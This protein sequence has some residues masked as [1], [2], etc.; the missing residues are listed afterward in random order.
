[1]VVCWHGFGSDQ[2]LV[3]IHSRNYRRSGYHKQLFL[4]FGLNAGLLA[5]VLL[6][7]LL[8]PSI[9]DSGS[10]SRS[11]SLRVD[12]KE[13]EYL[14]MGAGLCPL[15]PYC[16][17]ARDHLLRSNVCGLVHA[18]GR[19][20]LNFACLPCRSSKTSAKISRWQRIEWARL[21]RRARLAEARGVLA[22]RWRMSR[23][24]GATA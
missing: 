23:P 24:H 1:M 3:S 15:R 20:F 18:V 10:S 8:V 22:A 13:A 17:L 21:V 14:A 2:R 16:D 6:I 19:Y 9:S 5:M 7:F 12:V 11:C 4:A